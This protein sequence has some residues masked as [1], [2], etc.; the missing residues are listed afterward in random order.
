MQYCGASDKNDALQQITL[1]GRGSTR[2][3]YCF[4]ACV[5]S[6]VTKTGTVTQCLQIA[7]QGIELRFILV[8]LNGLRQYVNHIS[9]RW[10]AFRT[11]PL[12]AAEHKIT[13]DLFGN[14]KGMA[15]TLTV[16]FGIGVYTVWGHVPS[17]FVYLFIVLFVLEALIK[18]SVAERFAAST[19]E[20]QR[21]PIW[22]QI[23]VFGSLW[24]G[25]VYG[26]VGLA[27]F[28]PVS[29]EDRLILIGVF[30]GIV[31][32]SAMSGS[33]FQVISGWMIV[34][35]VLPTTLVLLFIASKTTL[36][37]AAM[38]IV[39]TGGAVFLGRLS[40]ERFNYLTELN[41]ENQRLLEVISHEQEVAETERKKAELAVVKNSR[42]MAAASHDLRQPLHAIGLFQH[43][44]KHKADVKEGAHLFESIDRS[45]TV[46]N[47]MFDSLLDISQLDA[48]AVSPNL[49][50]VQLAS[51]LTPLIEET[52]TSAAEKDLVFE[53]DVFDQRLSTDPVLLGRIV[54]NLL[55]NAVKF[56]DRGSVKL[57]THYSDTGVTIEIADTGVGIPVS[58]HSNIF[59][60][61]YQLTAETGRQHGVGLGLSI[62]NRLCQLLEIP[63]HVENNAPVGTVFSLIVPRAMKRVDGEVTGDS[64]R[65]TDSFQ[66]LSVVVIDD[67]RDIRTAMEQTLDLWQCR[68]VSFADCDDACHF[69]RTNHV[70]PDL[71]ICDYQLNSRRNG[72]EAIRLV[73]K[74]VGRKV[75]AI[76]ISGEKS[77]DL[78][79]LCRD[80]DIPL[81]SKPV[82]PETLKQSIAVSYRQLG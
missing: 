42:F 24:S 11:R 22:R 46:L 21:S 30:F 33:F 68:C 32:V 35:A 43:A 36:L 13:G 52:R 61:F 3:R 82:R 55:S 81:L 44:L 7:L 75:P 49:Q 1:Y 37:L 65:A 79:A 76:L 10:L 27:M 60:E 62:V 48:K 19:E 31:Q 29:I 41:E 72:L 38:L 77:T 58:E 57:S 20:Q 28:L 56:T 23:L 6:F 66:D 73:R 15:L 14:S 12:S 74:Q 16:C 71:L 64:E 80:E 40:A 67:E 9:Q 25:V 70:E 39:S 34:P 5:F 50:D 17:F 54:R 63:L 45:M 78:T 69:V 47:T 2:L 51:I 4:D 8:W 53:T 18:I 59:E 26:I